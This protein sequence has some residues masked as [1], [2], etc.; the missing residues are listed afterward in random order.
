MKKRGGGKILVRLALL[1]AL[2]VG[3]FL[4][5]Q[6]LGKPENVSKVSEKVEGL[7]TTLHLTNVLDIANKKLVESQPIL[8]DEVNNASNEVLGDTTSNITDNAKQFV[9]NAANQI[10][11]QI[12]DLPRQEAVNITR[13]VC[14]Q[15]IKDLE[16]K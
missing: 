1:T 15:I 6:K 12:K 3:G 11:D 10:S 13:S 16:K 2:G 5:Y 14:E 4:G 9:Q 7:A 8:V